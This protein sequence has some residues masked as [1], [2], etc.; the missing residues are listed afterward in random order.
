MG[1]KESL[2]GCTFA[3]NIILFSI[4]KMLLLLF[5]VISQAVIFVSHR[6]L[7]SL[8]YA[9]ASIGKGLSD[10]YLELTASPMQVLTGNVATNKYYWRVLLVFTQLCLSGKQMDTIECLHLPIA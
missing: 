4:K 9:L 7:K 2:K 3:K 1:Q 8:S 6:L 10:S 5:C